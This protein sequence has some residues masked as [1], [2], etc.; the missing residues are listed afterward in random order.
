MD[1]TNVS[2]EQN[3]P[4]KPIDLSSILLP[5]KEPTE[6]PVR[7]VASAIL[8]DQVAAQEVR[9]EARAEAATEPIVR[10]AP[11]PSAS[12]PNEVP[13]V[14]PVQTYQGDIAS[15]VEGTRVSVVSAAAAE[16]QRRA[17]TVTELPATYIRPVWPR[18]VM[19]AVAVG[20]FVG[21]IGLVAF[22]AMR[23]LPVE[24]PPAVSAPLLYID[25]QKTVVYVP[26]ESRVKL[27]S[28]L[29]EARDSVNLALGLISGVSVAAN[30]NA[31][32]AAPDLLPFIAPSMPPQLQ[33]TM[34]DEYMF[35]IHAFDGNQPF[36]MF[37]VDSYTDAYAGMLAWEATMRTELSPLFTRVPNAAAQVRQQENIS[38]ATSSAPTA[39]T[40]TPTTQT[41]PVVFVDQIVENRDARVIRDQYGN[42]LLLWTFLDR[43]TV[44]VTTNQYTL[45]EVVSRLSVAPVVAYPSARTRLLDLFR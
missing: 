18:I 4:K 30:D 41:A 24:P 35:G 27:L 17:Q 25:S 6:V 37:K 12:G 44:V 26:G 29:T 13:S 20:L 8:A 43:T 1:T 21:S 5:K 22:V 45:R 16:A 7:T 19:V 40:T 36:L 11:E 9:A 33:R 2:G 42:I 23:L 15:L 28:D 14:R 34:Q 38:T 10:L 32:I 3:N 39:S 31:T